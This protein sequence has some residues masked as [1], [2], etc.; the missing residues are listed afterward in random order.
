ML[1]TTTPPSPT[2]EPVSTVHYLLFGKQ[3]FQGERFCL[4]HWHL[5]LLL[6]LLTI[7]LV[8]PPLLR[9]VPLLLVLSLVLRSLRGSGPAARSLLLLGFRARAILFTALLGAVSLA[10]FRTRARFFPLLFSG[11]GSILAFLKTET[12]YI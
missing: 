10:V 1:P 9:P 7:L 5:F 4:L 6:L 8:S 11:L 2:W 3:F 12:G